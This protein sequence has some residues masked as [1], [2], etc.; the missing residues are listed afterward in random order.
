MNKPFVPDLEDFP[1]LR[2]PSGQILLQQKII[3]NKFIYSR[4]RTL[5]HFRTSHPTCQ[6]AISWNKF[7]GCRQKNSAA[8]KKLV[9]FLFLIF[10]SGKEKV[11]WYVTSLKKHNRRKVNI[12]SSVS[13]VG[14]F[15]KIVLCH[16]NFSRTLWVLQ[17]NIRPTGNI[18]LP[19]VAAF[20]FQ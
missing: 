8:G 17:P 3:Y 19:T 4:L 20:R 5:V 1:L 7:P 12:S 13:F 2:N 14:Y 16:S 10:L 11:Y 18:V 9:P 6:V 15:T